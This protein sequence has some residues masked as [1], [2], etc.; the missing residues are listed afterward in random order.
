MPPRDRDGSEPGHLRLVTSESRLGLGDLLRSVRRCPRPDRPEGLSVAE[1]ARR[2]GTDGEAPVSP[3]HWRRVEGGEARPQE[4]VLL[5]MALAVGATARQT[6]QLFHLAGYG[7][8]YDT[9]AGAA[10]GHGRRCPAE[11]GILADPRLPDEERRV[12]LEHLRDI[13]DALDVRARRQRGESPRGPEPDQ[14]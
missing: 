12:L 5:R 10:G 13:V 2:S 9:L 14:S 7:H 3:R 11:A 8:L 1:A 4:E 6:R